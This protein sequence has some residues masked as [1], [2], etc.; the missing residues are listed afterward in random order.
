LPEGHLGELIVRGPSVAQGYLESS[1]HR[2]S[3]IEDGVLRTGDAAFVIDGE[4][5]VLGRLGDSVKVF[6]RSIFAEDVEALLREAGVPRH[7]S[8]VVLGER[9]GVPAAVAVLEDPDPAWPD[10][11]WETL[12]ASCAGARPYVVC[13]PPGS[14][15]RTS[16]GKNR[17]RALW[18][19]FVSEKF[20]ITV[21]GGTK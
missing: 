17:R 8:A 6:A 21:N 19:D 18:Q 12:R 11:A 14:I 20:D 9:A 1:G 2:S 7:R 5:F 10:A 4:H 13:V 15:P 16:S 3:S